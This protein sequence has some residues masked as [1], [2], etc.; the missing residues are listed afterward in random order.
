MPAIAAKGKI[1][2]RSL[3]KQAVDQLRGQIL[4]GHLAAGERLVETAIAE[5]VGL[6]RSTIRGALAELAHE[7]L[8][9]QVAYTKWMV[10]E[11][12][13]E[14]AWDLYTLRSA[15]EGLAVRLAASQVTAE[16]IERIR[17][18]QQ[19][20]E[21]AA[22]RDDKVALAE[23]DF[24]LHEL[25]IELSGNAQL[26][27]HY[28]LIAQQVRL[29]IASSNSL[30]AAAADVVAQHKPIVEAICA[31]DEDAAE[32]LMREH[33]L[34]EGRRLVEHLRK[35]KSDGLPHEHAKEAVT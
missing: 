30:I 32:A 21:K 6:S 35:V 19:R 33:S 31:G 15:L 2:R 13:A 1:S 10:T 8:V 20:L 29:L 18:A 11:L 34:G 9:T 17:K 3:A 26:M 7:G 12:T 4:S 23:A 22:S 27:K 16:Q 14:S 28:R 24:S 25:L 5:E